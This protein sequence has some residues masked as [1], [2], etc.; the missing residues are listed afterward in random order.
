MND[1]FRTAGK[2]AAQ[3]LR[4]IHGTMS[5][6]A[7]NFN[8][9]MDRHGY[10]PR[11]DV[12]EAEGGLFLNV[13][14]S[15]YDGEMNRFITVIV[16]GYETQRGELS[17]IVDLDPSMG[18]RTNEDPQDGTL[19]TESFHALDDAAIDLLKRKCFAEVLAAAGTVA[20]TAYMGYY[21]AAAESLVGANRK[22]H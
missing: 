4:D 17:C 18:T 6:I 9:F 20:G 19:L 16:I 21:Q 2:Q 15:S 22:L 5:G 10:A 12:R 13:K 11:L 1:A 3:Y 14:D 8:D 7:A